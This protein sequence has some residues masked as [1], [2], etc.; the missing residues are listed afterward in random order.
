MVDPSQGVALLADRRVAALHGEKLGSL[1][2]LPRLELDGGEGGGLRVQRA[3]A[4]GVAREVQGDELLE[5]ADESAD[6]APGADAGEEGT[7]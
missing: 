4:Q 6:V 2:A 5:A 3:G 1:G 7:L